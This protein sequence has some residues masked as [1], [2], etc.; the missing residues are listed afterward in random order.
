MQKDLIFIAVDWVPWDFMDG[1]VHP[2]KVQV[3]WEMRSQAK[4]VGL[5]FAEQVYN[6]DM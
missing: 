5:R 2:Q 6:A 4:K 3:C 1:W